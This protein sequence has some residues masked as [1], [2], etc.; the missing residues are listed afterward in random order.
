MLNVYQWLGLVGALAMGFF[1]SQML[2]Q[3]Q[4]LATNVEYCYLSSTV[5]EQN[6][7]RIQLAQ[8][9]THPMQP[10]RMTVNWPLQ[11]ER[12]LLLTLRGLEMDMGIVKI[13]FTY[14][15]DHLY[16]A[17]LVLPICTQSKMTWIG[18]LS[19]GGLTVYPAVRTQQ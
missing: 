10:N 8:D 12:T 16:Q 6:N 14:V 1:V 18:E 15:G 7:V 19:D 5:C 13:P 3:N 11:G 2:Q 17:D 9:N 4:P